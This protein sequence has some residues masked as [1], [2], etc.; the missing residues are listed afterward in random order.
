MRDLLVKNHL[1][2]I[3]SPERFLRLYHDVPANVD[4]SCSL[5]KELEDLMP[6]LEQYSPLGYPWCAVSVW[7]CSGMVQFG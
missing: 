1:V 3:G 4:S 2:M 7:S 6:A 5:V